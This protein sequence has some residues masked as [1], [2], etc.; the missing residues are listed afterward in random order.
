MFNLQ[1]PMWQ[2]N[3]PIVPYMDPQPLF[4]ICIRD[5]NIVRIEESTK[6][7]DKFNPSSPPSSDTIVES[8]A[9][10]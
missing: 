9:G 6:S 10:R 1:G 7:G 3:R 8:L 4:H 5:Q 2:R